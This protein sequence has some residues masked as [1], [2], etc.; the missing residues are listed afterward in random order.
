MRLTEAEK[1]AITQTCREIFGDGSVYLFGSRTDDT[2]A[3]GDIDLYIIPPM[4]ES[5]KSLL[6]KKLY[7]SALL[8]QRIGDRKIDVIIAHNPNR[9][10]EQ[11]ALKK[12]IKL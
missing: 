7:F 11:E 12:G 4:K 6:E 2:Q 1:D 9:L 5:Y 8:K 3:G 10:I